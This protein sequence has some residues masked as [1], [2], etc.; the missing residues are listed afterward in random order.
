MVYAGQRG[1]FMCNESASVFNGEDQTLIPFFSF[2]PPLRPSTHSPWQGH[3]ELYG[4]SFGGVARQARFTTNAAF[5]FFGRA[6][7]KLIAIF[8]L[9]SSPI[10]ARWLLL[11][12]C[13]GRLNLPPVGPHTNQA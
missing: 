6:E 8:C 2:S 9:G 11:L 7:A 5:L 3:L 10:D 4:P 12:G 1:A 13:A